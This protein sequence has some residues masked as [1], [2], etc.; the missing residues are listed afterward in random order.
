MRQVVE[1]VQEEHDVELAHRGRIQV[2]DAHLPELD[3]G[4]EDA[5]GDGKAVGSRVHHR[6]HVVDRQHPAGAA[7]LAFEAVVAVGAA[8]VEHPRPGEA[9]RQGEPRYLGL[10][11]LPA[12]RHDAVA[13]RDP[14][15]PLRQ[16]GD[17][18]K[19]GVAIHVGLLLYFQ[20]WTTVR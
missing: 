13:Q 1:D 15:A 19:L 16:L 12:R 4:A 18:S 17:G 10:D 20:A 2:E 11:V 7:A 14:V 5:V 3:R 9:R 6:A 8:D